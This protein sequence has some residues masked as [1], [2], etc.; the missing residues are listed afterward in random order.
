LIG[1]RTVYKPGSSDELIIQAFAKLDKTALG[2]A[3]GLSLGLV[4]F[5]ATI[6]LVVKGGAQIGPNLALLSQYF[7]GYSV[8][9]TGG[10]IGLGYGL[11]L[12]FV[13]GWTTAFLRNFFITLY[14]YWIKL[15][16]RL[17]SANRFMD[18]L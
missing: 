10:V 12:G 15:K 2:V 3:V 11:L 16:C 6:S 1:K 14:V 4:I 7:T 17:G 13:L 18:H 8:T 5:I 9:L